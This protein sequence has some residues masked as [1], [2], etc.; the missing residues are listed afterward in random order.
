MYELALYIMQSL[1]PTAHIG[2]RRRTLG[3]PSSALVLL[4]KWLKH[5]DH[6]LIQ[7]LASQLH[8]WLNASRN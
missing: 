5:A 1:A 4:V 2:Y 8:D 3:T 6:A 7:C